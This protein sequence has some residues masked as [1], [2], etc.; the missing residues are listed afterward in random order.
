[1]TAP[2][3]RRVADRPDSAR[4]HGAVVYD[5]AAH[6]DEGTAA[7]VIVHRAEGSLASVRSRLEALAAEFDAAGCPSMAG[8]AR[9]IAREV[10]ADVPTRPASAVA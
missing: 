2:P 10:E 5:L 3:P 7:A 9:R 1:M 4:S 8:H 6:R